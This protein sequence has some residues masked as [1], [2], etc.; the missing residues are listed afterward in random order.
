M[1]DAYVYTTTHAQ[2]TH[3]FTSKTRSKSHKTMTNP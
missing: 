2:D 1:K 3:K